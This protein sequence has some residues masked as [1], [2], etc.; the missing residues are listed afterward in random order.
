MNKIKR[1]LSLILIFAILVSSFPMLNTFNA[2]ASTIVYE[3]VQGRVLYSYEFRVFQLINNERTK[4]GLSQLK[5]SAE[6]MNASSR[7]AAEISLCYS[8]GR[9]NGEQNPF[10]VF[11]WKYR[12]AENIAVNQKT[13]EQVVNAWMNSPSHRRN[14]LSKYYRS[15]GV[16]CF[17]ADGVIYWE[18]FFVDNKTSRNVSRPKDKTITY[19]IPIQ[20]SRVILRQKENVVDIPS[21]CQRTLKAYQLSTTINNFD[22]ITSLRCNCLT[23]SSSDTNVATVDSTGLVTGIEC[24]TANI[25]AYVKGYPT[26]K[27]TWVVNIVP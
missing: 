1:K 10:S 11:N 22:F 2:G 27:L 6:L 14:I 18:Q 24:G 9:P 15:M 3:K 23:F 12:V 17:K 4:R 13:P 8:H 5:M 26:R 19:S 20:K 21:T 16:G 7:R 25:T